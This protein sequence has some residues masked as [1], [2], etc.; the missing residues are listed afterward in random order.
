M[1]YLLTVPWLRAA[2]VDPQFTAV[3]VGAVGHSPWDTPLAARLVNLSLNV[4]SQPQRVR[5]LGTRCGEPASLWTTTH[6]MLIYREAQI[7]ECRLDVVDAHL[8][9]DHLIEMQLL[10]R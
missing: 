4:E 5:S 3:K 7:P 6:Q 2:D 9:R 1:D 8:T 10:V